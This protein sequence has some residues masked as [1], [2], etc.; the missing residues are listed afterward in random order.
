MNY[1]TF[2]VCSKLTCSVL[3]LC[4]VATQRR[5][6]APSQVAKRKQGDDEEDEEWTC[7]AVSELVIASNGNV[8]R[9]PHF[10]SFFVIN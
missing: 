6:L 5:S 8:A 3:H 4:L 1:C 10:R 9:L 2:K 7:A